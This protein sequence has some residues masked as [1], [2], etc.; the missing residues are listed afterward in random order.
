VILLSIQ[1]CFVTKILSGEKRIEFRRIW[2]AQPVDRVAIYSTAPI[3][4]VV[5]IATVSDVVQLSPSALWDFAKKYGAGITRDGLREYL[6]GCHTAYGIVFGAVSVM[7]SPLEL[8]KLKYTARA[9]QSFRYLREAER[10]LVFS[11]V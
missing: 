1:P 5:A 9:P 2:A 10:K 8:T 11:L 4:R 3:S 7:T 6:R